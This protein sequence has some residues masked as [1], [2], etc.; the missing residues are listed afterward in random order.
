MPEQP[1]P[2]DYQRTIRDLERRL[3]AAEAALSR[4]QEQITT[5][6]HP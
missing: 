4:L 3:A 1:K 5:H 6:T 2:R